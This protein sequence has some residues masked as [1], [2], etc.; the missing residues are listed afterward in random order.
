MFTLLLGIVSAILALALHELGRLSAGLAVGFHFSLFGLG[1]IILER[2]PSGR[3]RLAWNRTPA[4]FGGVAATLPTSFGSLRSRFAMVIGGGPIASLLL[5]GAAAAA[6]PLV[7]PVHGAILTLLGWLRLLSS[8]I[9]MGTAIP[10]SN[11]SFVTDGLRFLRIISR[12]QHADRE[13][14]LL[15]IVA[16]SCTPAWDIGTREQLTKLLAASSTQE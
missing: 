6:I 7:P 12:G 13:V 4:F 5:A 2:V 10:L 8:L 14:G 15:T 1:P 3:I 9:F 16:T 11:G